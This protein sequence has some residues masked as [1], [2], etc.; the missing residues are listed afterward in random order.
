L[1][2]WFVGSLVGSLVRW[3]VGSLVRWFV[4]SLVRSLVRW[5]VCL[6]LLNGVVVV[7]GV[8]RCSSFVVVVACSFVVVRLELEAGL[9][10]VVLL[11]LLLAAVV[12]CFPLLAWS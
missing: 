2:R 3:F 11:L 12:A 4:G 7:V 1:V 6:Y 5:F 10:A 8:A 9:F